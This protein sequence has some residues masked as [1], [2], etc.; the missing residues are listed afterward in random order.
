[1]KKF[2]LLL[3]ED[4]EA[5]A[6][7]TRVTLEENQA[8]CNFYHVWDGLEALAFLRRQGEKF[9]AAPSPDLILLDLNMPRFNGRELLVELKQDPQLAAIPVVIFTTSDSER[10]VAECFSRGAAGYIVKPMGIE[11][12]AAALQSLVRYWFAVST[13]P[14]R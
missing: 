12:L 2:N 4:D 9:Q 6:Y 7:M 5:D 14:G 10:D 8:P 11:R 13:L 1:M 3:V